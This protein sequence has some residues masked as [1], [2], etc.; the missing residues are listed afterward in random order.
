ML[1]F[2]RLD[3]LKRKNMVRA[4]GLE[5]ALPYGNKILSP[6]QLLLSLSFYCIILRYYFLCANK[7]AKFGVL[8][9]L[10]YAPPNA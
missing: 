6:L 3:A 10:F 9:K 7:C 1:F 2:S 8:C 4:A 5:P